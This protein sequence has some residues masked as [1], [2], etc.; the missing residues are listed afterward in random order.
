MCVQYVCSRKYNRCSLPVCR[1]MKTGVSF[2]NVNKLFN[3]VLYK[4]LLTC[5]SCI[6]CRLMWIEHM[7]AN[8]QSLYGGFQIN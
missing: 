7:V 6:C 1:N 5:Q 2:I 3:I 4:K 8:L